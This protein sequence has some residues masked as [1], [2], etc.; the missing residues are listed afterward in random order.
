MLEG[1]YGILRQVGDAPICRY[2]SLGSVNE[3][4]AGLVVRESDSARRSMC[5]TLM[6]AA[7]RSRIVDLERHRVVHRPRER[8]IPCDECGIVTFYF[9]DG[10][11]EHKRFIHDGLGYVQTR[12]SKGGTD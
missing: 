7:W 3:L 4:R 9:K 11:D 12:G 10:R 5:M 1:V 8:T 2:F 6:D